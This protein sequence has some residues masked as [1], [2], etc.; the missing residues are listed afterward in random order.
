M[1]TI[2]ALMADLLVLAFQ[3]RHHADRHVHAGQRR[4]QSASYPFIGVPDGHH[5]LSHHG[6]N[7]EKQDKIRKINRFHMEQFAYLLGKLKSIQEGERSL[8]DNSMIVYGGGISDGNRHNHDDL[9]VLLAGKGG[10]TL[11]TGRHIVYPKNTPL[12][13]LFLSMLDKLGVK[14]DSLGDST[15]RLGKLDDRRRRRILK[16]CFSMDWTVPCKH[17]HEPGA[18]ALRGLMAI[19]GL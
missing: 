6:G 11:R 10:G 12:N 4:E 2:S 9:P 7:Q 15:G 17:R 3:S 5:D 14:A 16:T 8:L 18:T 1:P 19:A 13:N